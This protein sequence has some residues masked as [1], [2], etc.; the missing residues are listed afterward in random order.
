[1]RPATTV[2]LQPTRT[3]TAIRLQ[4]SFGL[5]TRPTALL[6]SRGRRL[7]GLPALATFR[8]RGLALGGATLCPALASS[9][10]RAL[11]PAQTTATVGFQHDLLGL[12]ALPAF[13]GGFLRDAAT[14]GHAPLGAL[15][16]HRLA[17]G[18]LL[19]A[20][21][22]TCHDGFPCCSGRLRFFAATSRP[23]PAARLLRGGLFLRL[24]LAGR[25]RTPG[26][27]V[28][29]GGLLPDP[30]LR[31]RHVVA[32]HRAAL[33]GVARQAPLH[34]HRAGVLRVA[35]DASHVASEGLLLRRSERCA[36]RLTTCVLGEPAHRRASRTVCAPAVDGRDVRHRAIP[37]HGSPRA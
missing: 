27:F 7:P 17:G 18:A 30:F 29:L 8:S 1:M 3:P 31:G 15:A 13:R 32:A 19:S 24:P 22:S 10:T 37:L 9:G 34:A 26:I 23:N 36:G 2:G 35:L 12:T 4:R 6:R 16:S 14:L 5:A 25:G 33:G 11:V 20:G 21:F 28:T